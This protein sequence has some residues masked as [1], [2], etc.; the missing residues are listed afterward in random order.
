[1]WPVP[2]PRY[3]GS[4]RASRSRAC[5]A[6]QISPR[7]ARQP[8]PRH[9]IDPPGAH[10]CASLHVKGAGG[11][12]TTSCDLARSLAE[13]GALALPW[14]CRCCY[15]QHCCPGL[16]AHPGGGARPLPHPGLRSQS[17][18]YRRPPRHATVPS[19]LGQRRPRERA[20]TACC[21]LRGVLA[22]HVAWQGRRRDRAPAPASHRARPQPAHIKPPQS[23]RDRHLGL[24]SA[25]CA[26]KRHSAKKQAPPDDCREATPAP[27]AR[28]PT[29]EQMSGEPGA[30]SA[31]GGAPA[32][33]EP[34]LELAEDG[35]VLP[36]LETAIVASS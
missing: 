18:R 31:G 20:R 11:A 27:K 28:H 16:R 25:S 19:S 10:V 8:V 7:R 17:T 33:W 34:V 15:H 5:S 32:L 22:L 35:L 13:A 4:C 14:R 21:Q 26:A 29:A 36:R 3:R 9:G 24:P 23:A 1:M 2:H 6:S 12:L 30:A